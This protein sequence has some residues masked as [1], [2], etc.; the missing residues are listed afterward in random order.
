[1]AAND[2]FDAYYTEKIWAMI[3]AVYRTEDG[4]APIPGVLR[5]L[6]QVIAAQAAITRRSIDR[7]WEDQSIETCDDWATPYIGDLVGTLPLPVDDPRAR[8]VDVAR[9][10]HFRRRRGTPSLLESLVHE[11]SGWSV[12]LVEAFR[13]LARAPHRLDTFPVPAGRVTGTP[14]G[15]IADLRSAR[16]SE[17]LPG[18]FDE[19]SHTPDVRRLRG[20]VGRFNIPKVNF[21]LY[22]L[23]AFGVTG[24]TPVQ[25][26]DPGPLTFTVDPSGRD[27]PLFSQE[28][29]NAAGLDSCEPPWGDLPGTA[30]GGAPSV[31]T[32]QRSCLSTFEWQ[33]ARP[34]TCRELSEAA[35]VLTAENVSNATNG[36]AGVIA[37]LAPLYGF[38]FRDEVRLRQRLQQLG[39]SFSPQ[40][41]PWYRALLEDAV[42]ADSAAPNLLAPGQA[43]SL[44]ISPAPGLD[45]LFDQVRGADLDARSCQ[46][47]PSD[48]GV[49]LLVD[50]D[51]GRFAVPQLQGPEPIV[52]DPTPTPD[53]PPTIPPTTPPPTTPPP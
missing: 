53:P 3:P 42:T 4:N 34:M 12:V 5:Q 39:L 22:R 44:D 45:L 30:S 9:T 19:L 46:P 24:S 47:V 35:F 27:V 32:C 11:L 31:S 20:T 21:H 2:G 36:D 14:A 26:Q 33:V 17:L 41:P 50:V 37:L 6:V 7:L 16:S 25:M 48:I 13:R 1:M 40:Q 18:P 51:L 38:R 15:G 52:P 8:R 29:T 28:A 43:K 49:E 23:H 10:I